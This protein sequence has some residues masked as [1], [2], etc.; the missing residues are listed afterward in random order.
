MVELKK[1]FE[2]DSELREHVIIG[3]SNSSSDGVSGAV[4]HSNYLENGTNQLIALRQDLYKF[5]DIV[6][7]SK[8]SDINYFL[9]KKENCSVE[10][11]KRACGKLMPCVHGSDAHQNNKIFEPDKKRYCWI[12]SDVTFNGFKQ[13]IY[14][15]NERVRISDTL[16][17]TKPDYYV[18]DR[19]EFSDDRFQ[20]EPIFFNDNLTCIIGGKSTGK[21]ILLQ[22]MARSIDKAEA[23][24][25]L[26]QVQTKTLY[27]DNIK[28][29]WKDGHDKPRK[30]IYIPQ[31]YLNKLSDE[32]QEK[33]EVDNWIQEIIL[34]EENVYEAHEEFQHSLSKYK[35]ELEKNIVDLIEKHNRYI[36]FS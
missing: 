36:E 7:S 18:I 2:N 22:N 27:I 16:P 11:V 21:L 24:K 32:K 20:K 29:Y 30:I 4:N 33:T 25:Y 34:R 26:N 35:V 12:K 6:F 19:V 31:T 15:P 1:L 14:E 10:D 3:V 13:I 8:Q 28:V 23:E 17:G 5:V 9:G